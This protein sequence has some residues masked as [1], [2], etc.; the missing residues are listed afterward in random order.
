MKSPLSIVKE[1]FGDK[2][3]LVAAV[4]T[5]ATKDLWLDRVS[6]AK[7]LANV[8]NAKLLKLHDVLSRAKQEFGTRDKLIAA[9]LTATKRG[10]D[11]G[12][13]QRLE[14]YPLPR[15]L[16]THKSATRASNR[17]AKAKPKTASAP[18]AKRPRS[19]K[20]KAKAAAGAK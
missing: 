3:K 9:I 2:T 15:L 18:A 14:R 17:A 10:K 1:R 6:E 5:L 4:Q 7:G 19:K 16:D 20:A 11:A 8:S 12:L 13:K